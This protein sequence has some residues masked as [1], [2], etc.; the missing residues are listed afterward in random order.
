MSRSMSPLPVSARRIEMISTIIITYAL[1]ADP[2]L[3]RMK[4]H[5]SFVVRADHFP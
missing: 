4:L 1:I 2:I 5:C 3:A